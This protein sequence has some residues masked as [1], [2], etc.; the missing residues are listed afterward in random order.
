MVHYF[1]PISLAMM[2][3]GHDLSALI[4]SHFNL[5][6]VCEQEDPRRNR[7]LSHIEGL[8]KKL[9]SYAPVDA[10]VDQKAREFLHDCLPPVLTPGSF[11]SHANMHPL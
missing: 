4:P 3:P 8:M 10:A 6:D 2:K 1:V 7:F 5:H 11:Y 9:V